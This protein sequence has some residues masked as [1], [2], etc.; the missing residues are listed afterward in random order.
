MVRELGERK[1]YFVLNDFISSLAFFS[2]HKLRTVYKLP[3]GS[4]QR[5]NGKIGEEQDTTL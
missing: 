1:I 2:V 4:S 5:V 3:D